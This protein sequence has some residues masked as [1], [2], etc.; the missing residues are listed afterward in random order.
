MAWRDSGAIRI[1][2]TEGLFTFVA[3]DEE[4]RPR[5]VAGKSVEALS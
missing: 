5:P 3:I 4:A 2:V 1:K